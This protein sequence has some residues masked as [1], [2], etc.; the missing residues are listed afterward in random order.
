MKS[1][2]TLF[3]TF[4]LITTLLA[5]T[6]GIA[7]VGINTTT[8]SGGSILD[9]NSTNKGMLVPR[10]SINN[11]NTI[12]PVTG[13]GT[14]SLLV[15]NTNT[16][17][18][19]G[20]YYWDNI[21]WVNIGNTVDDDWDLNGNAGTDPSVNY[22]GTSDSQP[23]V[24]GANGNEHMRLLT[25]GFF[26]INTTTAEEYLDVNG[27]IDIGGGT[28]DWDSDGE[29]IHFRAQSQQWFIAA[30]NEPNAADSDFYISTGQRAHN[31]EFL[32][33]PAGNIN[34]GED[35]EY[36]PLDI[37]HITKDQEDA[38]TIRLDNTRN[39][40]ST[41]HQALEFWDGSNT[42]SSTTGL[43]TFIRHNNRDHIMDIGHAKA[44]GVVNFYS[45]DS[46]G[47]NSDITM[48]LDNE[49]RV[50]I[51][52]TSPDESSILDLSSSDAG[53]LAP[54]VSL[55]SSTDTSTISGTEATGLMV[56]NT[57]TAGD[58]T[59]GYY[60]WDGARWLAM[61]AGTNNDWNLTGNTGTN[62]SINYIGTA[63]N[64]PFVFKTN[65]N[66]TMRINQNGQLLIGTTTIDSGSDLLQ[67]SS[68]VE[69]GGGPTNHDHVAE[70]IKIRSQSANWYLNAE[71]SSSESNSNFYIGSTTGT[72]GASLLISRAGDVIIGND[73]STP[74]SELHLVKD[75]DATTAFR[76]DNTNAGTNTI[77][78]AL[79][80]WDGSKT[81]TVSSGLQAFFRNN[82]NTHTLDIGHA[83]SDGVVN[84][85]A[86][87]NPG[88]STGNS[89]LTMTLQN[90]GDVEMHED[91]EVA[92]SVTIGETLRL[93][94]R[95]T[96]PGS[97]QIG[98]IYYDS[99]DNKVKVYTGT[100]EDL[101]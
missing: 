62:P 98:E 9:V 48:T 101:N 53:F 21:K 84:F 92:E 78:Q 27:D 8:P 72:G 3:R 41:I 14:E 11:L 100:W 30:E 76:I 63:D 89:G 68:D 51:G 45:G 5:F 69:V 38:T 75:Q 88:S 19:K 18:G 99:G 80:L 6:Q 34:I 81:G 43:Q 52:T 85:Y 35:N 10:V 31:A 37:L 46:N 2:F 50:G 82:N 73:D 95:S 36:D 26:G 29:N 77:H 28:A 22:V 71:N 64:Q 12:A 56:Y 74:N 91:L 90:D 24:F 86:G 96:A 93:T 47:S 7:Q 65:N 49:N 61:T 87:N 25:N 4:T 20:F 67:V 33:T 17:T 59:P 55:N 57:A 39:G 44:D 32:I 83:K 16:S 70:N 66:E 1:I 94:P 58:V 40:T 97:P 13:G 23:L 60:H 54:R 79:E 42:S 15:Y